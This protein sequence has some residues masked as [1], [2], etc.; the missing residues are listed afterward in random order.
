MIIRK[1]YAFLIKN[2]KKIHIFLLVLCAYVYYKNMQTSAFIKEFIVLGTYDA[3]NEPITK[4]I[5]FLSIFSLII[6]ILGSVTLVFLLKHKNKPWKLYLLPIIVYSLMLISFVMARGY[7]LSY[8]GEDGTAGVRAV[9]DLLFISTIFEYP[10]FIVFLMRIFG[11]DLHKFNFKVDEEY[12]ELDSKDQ[13]ELEINIDIDKESFK[14]GLK[15]LL[16]N[17]NYVYQEHKLVCNTLAVIAFVIVAKN[18]YTYIFITHKAYRQGDSLNANGYT[19]KIN[20]SYYTDKDYRG[21]LI[22][23]ENGFVILDLTIKNN[24]APREVDFNKFH[25][26]NGVNNYVT[27]HK[28]YGTEFQDFG[29]TY[30]SKKLRRDETLNLI[31]VYRVSKKLKTNRFVLYYQELNNNRPYL[32]KIK[33]NIDDVSIIKKNKTIKMNDDFSFVVKKQ[34][35]TVNFAYYEIADSSDYTYRICNTSNCAT[36][37]ANYQAPSG[38][39]VL[40]IEFSSDNYEGKDMID[41]STKYGKIKYIDSKNKE[42]IIKIENPLYRVHY[43]KYMYISVPKEVSSAKSIEMVY[44]VRNNQYVYKLK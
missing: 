25:V 40:K 4:Y 39:S 13:E 3:Y 7:F 31:L 27:T 23:K 42:K 11:V 10:V 2:F 44:T 32:R 35:E 36:H 38:K 9:R 20:K 17:L 26:M 33:L 19:I 30:K 24:E 41:F 1:P 8:T 34:K 28:M 6:I 43:G 21:D 5:T 15:R 22:S 14:R 18:T 16:R 29:T 12:L 37:T